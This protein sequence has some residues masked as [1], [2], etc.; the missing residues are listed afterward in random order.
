MAKEAARHRIAEVVESANEFRN[1]M[2]LVPA[3]SFLTFSLE[4]VE[5]VHEG[6]AEAG[7]LKFFDSRHDVLAYQ[8]EGG[9]VLFFS[10][11]CLAWEKVGPNFVQLEAMRKAVQEVASL[12]RINVE[13]LSVWLD[14]LSIP[15]LDALAKEAAIDS[16]YT[17]ACISDVMVVV[18]PESVHANTGKQAG[19]ESVKQRFWCRLEQTAFCCQRGAG[20]MHLH[21]G[22]GLESVPDHWLDTVC[23]VHDSE[24]TCCR[25]RHC[26]RSRCD[27]E[28]SVAPLL[29]LYHDIY[30][31]A[32][33]PE[34][35]KEDTHIWSLIRRNRDRVFPKSFQFLCGA[36]EE[37]RE[38]FG[39]GVEQVERLVACE[40]LAKSAA[41]T[42]LSGG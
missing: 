15:Q 16:I 26:G 5:K 21:D 19:R 27:R 2:V 25:L 39:D 42:R 23:C 30:S 20:R 7:S 18:C 6:L 22:N 9:T 3:L 29:A 8:K 13:S 10:Y 32:M 12:R 24:M 35:R 41:P 14:C 36:G 28:R 37:V 40:I 33:S 1:P 34:C 17:Y 11:E 31:R 4:D 38:L